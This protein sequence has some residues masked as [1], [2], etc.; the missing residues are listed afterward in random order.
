MYT[1]FL[2]NC[3]KPLTNGLFATMKIS[4][5]VLIL[6]ILIFFANFDYPTENIMKTPRLLQVNLLFRLTP[7]LMLLAL[8]SCVGNKKPAEGTTANP[9]QEIYMKYCMA[10][11]Q[12]SGAGVPGMYP[13]L[14]KT[15]W[16]HG[17]KSRLIGLLLNGQQGE[18]KVNDQVFRGVMPTHQY[19]TDEQIADVLTYVRSNF[20]NTAD[21]VLPEEVANIR[22]K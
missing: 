13:T 21:A 1:V 12:A 19:L 18:I 15:D 5:P 2:T 7:A 14:Q 16:V 22:Q 17:D 6:N 8:V 11:H 4:S 3:F 9:G 10:C 20:G